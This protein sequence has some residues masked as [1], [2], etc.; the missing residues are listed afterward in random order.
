MVHELRLRAT[1]NHLALG[2]PPVP[3]TRQFARG[4]SF[5]ADYREMRIVGLLHPDAAN[6]FNPQWLPM[7]PFVQF[8]GVFSHTNIATEWIQSGEGRRVATFPHRHLR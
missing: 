5:A 6:P 4:V 8:A 2:G 3:V 7:I 1:V